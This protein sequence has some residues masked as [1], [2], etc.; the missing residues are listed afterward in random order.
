MADSICIFFF[1]FHSQLQD[2]EK[3]CMN[4][5]CMSWGACADVCAALSLVAPQLRS[6]PACWVAQHPYAPL[7]GDHAGSD[8]QGV[9][10]ASPSIHSGPSGW[11]EPLGHM[12]PP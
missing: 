2:L 6:A 5:A 7:A 8:A 10:I 1:L 12:R 9:G 11:M 3:A 4:G